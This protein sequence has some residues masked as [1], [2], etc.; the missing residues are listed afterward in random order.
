MLF[1]Q[2]KFLINYGMDILNPKFQIYM[3]LLVRPLFSFRKVEKNLNP[4]T[5]KCIF[6]G[7]N[8]ETKRYTFM[9]KSNKRI[10]MSKDVVFIKLIQG[11]D[12]YL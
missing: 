2:I 8:N 3:C 6:L 5:I 12:V 7:H 4:H 10:I 9:S 11:Q 1:Y